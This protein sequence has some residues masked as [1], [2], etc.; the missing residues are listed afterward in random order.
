MKNMTQRSDDLL[1]YVNSE[2]LREAIHNY[3]KTHRLNAK[4]FSGR[5]GLSPSTICRLQKNSGGCRIDTLNKIAAVLQ[6]NPAKLIISRKTQVESPDL[7]AFH[8]RFPDLF[9]LPEDVQDLISLTMSKV[10][11]HFVNEFSSKEGP[12]NIK[13]LNKANLDSFS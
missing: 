11:F 8:R 4:D 2:Y 5:V 12:K 3:L 7:L 13:L 6:M 1:L 9:N 10:K